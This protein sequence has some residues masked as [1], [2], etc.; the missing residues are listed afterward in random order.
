M[1]TVKRKALGRGLAALI[2]GASSSHASVVSASDGART[3]GGGGLELIAIEEVHP[4]REQPRKLFARANR[5]Q[6]RRRNR[7]D[8]LVGFFRP[9]I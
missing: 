4:S 7:L 6:D 3:P 1:S 8:Y 5:H 2:P 9:P